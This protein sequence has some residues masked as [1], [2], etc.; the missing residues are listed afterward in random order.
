MCV[1][2]SHALVFFYC[3]LLSVD[4][5]CVYAFVQNAINVWVDVWS[6]WNVWEVRAATTAV[7]LRN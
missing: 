7:V 1:C 3:F 2:V 4:V 6:L 5:P